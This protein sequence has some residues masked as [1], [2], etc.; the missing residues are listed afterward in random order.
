MGNAY[1]EYQNYAAIAD[2]A[3]RERVSCLAAVMV[4]IDAAPRGTKMVTIARL[5]EMHGIPAKTLERQYLRWKKHGDISLADGRKM[6][7][8]EADNIFYKDFKTYAENDRNTCKGGYNTMLR[9]IRKGDVPP[10]V[11]Q[12]RPQ[13]W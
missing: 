9:D 12:H 3:E 6:V 2:W 7:R 13:C 11:R 8:G 4:Q 5:G 1:L 10:P